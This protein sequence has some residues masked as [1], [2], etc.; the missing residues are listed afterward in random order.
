[1]LL[2]KNN[3]VFTL[4]GAKLVLLFSRRRSAVLNTLL[5]AAEDASTQSTLRATA[6]NLGSIDLSSQNCWTFACMH[7]DNVDFV[8]NRYNHRNPFPFPLFNS[9]SHA[10]IPIPISMM[11][12]QWF[13]FS[14]NPMGPMGSQTVPFPCTPLVPR[15][16]QP[17]ILRGTVNVYHLSGWV[18]INRDGGCR[19]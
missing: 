7:D 13:P 4:L 15:S 2:C 8:E 10:F 12:S 3:R 17:S 16:T 9:H 19:R 11:E 5:L 1:M 6:Y 18:I 14:W